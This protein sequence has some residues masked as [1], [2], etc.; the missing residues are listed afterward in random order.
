MAEARAPYI[1]VIGGG[2]VG[3]YLTKHLLEAGYEVALVEK[4]RARA[5]ALGSH[6]GR[7]AIL[8]GDGDEMAFLASTGIERASV[9]AA[10]TG[11]DEDN[12]VACQLARRTFEVPR[13]LARVNNPRNVRLF[14]QLGVDVA[15]SAT[16]VILGVIDS[17]L[18][19]QGDVREL[20]LDGTE[21]SLVRITVPVGPLV[22]HRTDEVASLAQERILLVV[23]GGAP[24]EATSPLEAGDQVVVFSRR[25]AADLIHT[26]LV[27][28]PV[29]G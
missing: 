13:T 21:A 6:L 4:D 19:H 23:R 9:V 15:V 25:P 29:G 16:D 5:A 17:E 10:V 26:D 22:G 18:A 11:D 28:A 12:L 1:L 3:Y 27:A 7:C 20:P 24:I 8:V 2:K 14:H